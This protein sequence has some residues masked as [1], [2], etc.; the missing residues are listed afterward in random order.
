[1]DYLRWIDDGD[2]DYKQDAVSLV[3]RRAR[4]LLSLFNRVVGDSVV[5]QSV[6]VE[7]RRGVSKLVANPSA[8][9]V[10]TGELGAMLGGRFSKSARVKLACSVSGAAYAAKFNNSVGILSS[11]ISPI[12]CWG[13]VQ[14]VFSADDDLGEPVV[15][16]QFI[17]CNS[18]FAGS[19]IWGEMRGSSAMRYARLFKLLGSFRAK[20]RWYT[21]RQFIDA[22]ATIRLQK[23]GGE[24]SLVGVGADKRMVLHNRKL[25]SSR[26]RMHSACHFGATYDCGECVV[27]RNQCERS[28]FDTPTTY[29][30]SMEQ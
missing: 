28:C 26:S 17:A 3:S 13:K 20:H 16:L 19:V 29:K 11:D 25:A 21:N 14:S 8:S 22:A 1:M 7:L 18:V 6:L 9:Q 24:L 15:R 30:L 12:D 5:D 10:V 23:I 27:G 2:L 4:K